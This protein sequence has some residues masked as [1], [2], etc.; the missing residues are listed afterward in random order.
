MR[1]LGL[2]GGDLAGDVMGT[3]D[4]IGDGDDVADA[5]AAVLAWPAA[6]HGCP[7]ALA[8]AASSVWEAV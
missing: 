4:Q 1:G 5:L 8:R 3:F 2:G 6:H 7:P